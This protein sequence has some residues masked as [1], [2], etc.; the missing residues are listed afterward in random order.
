MANSGRHALDVGGDP[1]G[2]LDQL[3][4]LR[5]RPSR[6]LKNAQVS[7][8]SNLRRPLPDE[9]SDELRQ[10][11]TRYRSR[12]V[13]DQLRWHLRNEIGWLACKAVFIGNAVFHGCL[14]YG[15]R[16]YRSLGQ[17]RPSPLVII[18]FDPCAPDNTFMSPGRIAP[19]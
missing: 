4:S 15:L 9:I 14:V 3:I 8:S 6:G 16:C 13:G 2:S 5:R 19:P 12:Y 18:A 11:N 10:Q 17:W 1:S 7:D